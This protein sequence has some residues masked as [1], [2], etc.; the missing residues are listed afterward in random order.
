MDTNVLQALRYKL[1]K[2]LKRINT[3]DHQIF[4]SVVVQT[5]QYL[6]EQ[7]VVHGILDDLERRVPSADADGER[8]FNGE[9][10]TGETATEHIA[11]CHA[12]AKRAPPTAPA[13]EIHLCLPLALS[14]QIP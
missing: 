4:H 14:P 12:V 7:P 2:R 6:G 8:I 5:F 13:T 11:L 10:L 3:A 9:L 1:Q